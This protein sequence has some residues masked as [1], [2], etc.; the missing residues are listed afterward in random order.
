MSLWLSEFH[1]A[2]VTII[3]FFISW[4]FLTGQLPFAPH[5]PQDDFLRSCL[6]AWALGRE[7]RSCYTR[8]GRLLTT[9]LPNVCANCSP[10]PVR[11]ACCWPVSSPGPVCLR[12][13]SLGVFKRDTQKCW[14]DLER[15]GGSTSVASNKIPQGRCRPNHPPAGNHGVFPLPRGGCRAGAWRSWGP[16]PG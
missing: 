1:Q 9:R 8:Q 2:V 10:G 7:P 16:L 3:V 4:E 12:E 11:E 15:A 5:P 13:F 14:L 6:W